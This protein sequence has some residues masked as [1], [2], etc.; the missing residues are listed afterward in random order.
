MQMLCFPIYFIYLTSDLYYFL[1]KQGHFSCI[2]CIFKE[3]ALS[4]FLTKAE[5]ARWI[6]SLDH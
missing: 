3:A 2:E 6:T 1:L 4:A 5:M